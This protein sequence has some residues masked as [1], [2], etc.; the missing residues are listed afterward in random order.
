LDFALELENPVQVE[1]STLEDYLEYLANQTEHFKFAPSTDVDMLCCPFCLGPAETLQHIFFSCPLARLLWLHSKWP[2]NASAF[3]ALPISEWS[4][5]L[6]RPHDL[7]GIPLMEVRQ[8][9]IYSLIVLDNIWLA[10]NSLIHKAVK[11]DPHKILKLIRSSFSHHMSAWSAVS[12]SEAW[13]PPPAGSLKANFDVVVRPLF[14]VAA[15]TI[16]D[17]HG[18]FVAVSSLML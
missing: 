9:Q 1:A 12:D 7:L 11:P 3:S 13:V 18:N 2:L 15:A 8:F 5:A 14:S 10:R 16:R 4:Q 17:H 6:L